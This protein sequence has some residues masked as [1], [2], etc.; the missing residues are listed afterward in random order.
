[1][2]LRLGGHDRVNITGG[3]GTG[4]TVLAKK[5]TEQFADQGLKVAFICYNKALGDINHRHFHNNPLVNASTYFGFFENL[6]G[7]KLREF[8]QEVESAYPNADLWQ[9]L[10]PFAFALALEE[11]EGVKYDAVI[12]D[13]AQDLGAEMW[14]PIEMLAEAEKLKFFISSDTN[15]SLYSNIDNIPKLS[16]PFL[17]HTNCRNTQK[18]HEEAYKNYSGPMISP[19]PLKGLPVNRHNSSL[20]IEQS[21][22]IIKTLDMLTKEQDL[23][24]TDVVVLVAKSE[25][26][27]GNLELLSSLKTKYRFIED[28]TPKND[29]FR[30]STIKRFKGLEALAIIIWGLNEL[31]ES[32]RIELSYVGISRAQSL[33]HLIN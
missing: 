21:D 32:Q 19:P 26:F 24:L 22:L 3:A 25:N 14:M 9:V 28:E 17:L 23:D 12:V 18:I 2:F 7:N 1:M 11:I 16:S 10:K 30:V 31:P 29:C 8:I 15:Q 27:R 20:V 5:L 13:E 6:I 33:C 4:K